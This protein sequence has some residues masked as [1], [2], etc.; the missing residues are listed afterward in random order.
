MQ[1]TGKGSIVT[2]KTRVVTAP[3]A[4]VELVVTTASA[5][6]GAGLEP[7]FAPGAIIAT[8][9]TNAN[10]KGIASFTFPITSTV[11]IPGKAAKILKTV[12][13]QNAG[14]SVFTLKTSATI[15]EVR[16]RLIVQNDETTRGNKR[17]A[18]VIGKPH[19]TVVTTTFTARVLADAGATVNGT[20]T[21]G[22]STI[23]AGPNTAGVG[24]RTSLKFS[25]PDSVTPAKG[26]ATLVTTSTYR[27]ATITRTIHFN[28][29]HKK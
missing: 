21:I 20:L 23:T 25:V 15:R 4:N 11:L 26:Q 17:S 10:A 13:I 2:D 18:F 29:A 14:G 19:G 3:N 12:T 8:Y 9:N 7:A 5:G 22:G 6:T 24:G 1:P 28:Y 27:G 16:L